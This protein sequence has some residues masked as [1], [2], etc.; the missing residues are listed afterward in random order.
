M[1]I[2]LVQK[3]SLGQGPGDRYRWEEKEYVVKFYIWELTISRKDHA[4]HFPTGTCNLQ[5]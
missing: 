2:P 5:V 3:L 1:L 4:I